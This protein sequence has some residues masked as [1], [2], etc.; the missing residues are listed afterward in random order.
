LGNLPGATDSKL[1]SESL[2]VPEESKP[3]IYVVD[4]DESVRRALKRLFRSAGMDVRVS[5]SGR[6]F[7]DSEFTEENACLVADVKMPELGGLELQQELIDRGSELPV[8]LITGFDTEET[9]AQAKK[10]G[11]AAYFRKPVDDQAL[12]DAIRWALSK[13]PPKSS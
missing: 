10:M 7:L 6:R 11:V 2:D 9:R 4:D 3:I 13:R 1:W 12:L 5:E 8:I